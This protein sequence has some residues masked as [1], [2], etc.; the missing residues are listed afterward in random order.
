M[1]LDRHRWATL[2]TA[3]LAF[4]GVVFALAVASTGADGSLR[5]ALLVFCELGFMAWRLFGAKSITR[6]AMYLGLASGALVLASRFDLLTAYAT[7][8]ALHGMWLAV[9]ITWLT[10]MAIASSLSR[11]NEREDLVPEARAIRR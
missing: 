6:T 9:A 7:P 1:T 11:V 10:I 2:T 8:F 5:W 3:G 4:L